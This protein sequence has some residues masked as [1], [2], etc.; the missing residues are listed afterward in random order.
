[1]SARCTAAMALIQLL[2]QLPLQLG[3]VAEAVPVGFYYN[4]AAKRHGA[5]EPCPVS[6]YCPGDGR[7]Y[8]CPPGRCC[9]SLRLSTL[10][11]DGD[12]LSGYFCR[13][14][15]KNCTANACGS[16]SVYCPRG[17][18]GPFT[19]DEGSFTVRSSAIDD[20]DR[21]W[22]RTASSNALPLS[23]FGAIRPRQPRRAPELTAAVFD[24]S[25]LRD[26]Q[27]PCDM[28]H[29]CTSGVRFTCP[30]GTFGST[31]ELKDASCSGPCSAG[32]WCGAGSV[33]GSANVCGG[34]GVFCPV[35]SAQPTPVAAGYYSL[36]A[37]DPAMRIALMHMKEDAV[38]QRSNSTR[39]RFGLRE[40]T[41]DRDNVHMRT[42]D[43]WDYVRVGAWTGL[44]SKLL[45]PPS[46]ITTRA[47]S[48]SSVQNACPPGTYCM[49]GVAALCPAGTFGATFGLVNSLCSGSCTS[50]FYCIAGST[51]AAPPHATCA[52]A[53]YYCPAASGQRTLVSDG[54]YT[55]GGRT[56]ANGGRTDHTMMMH[57]DQYPGS[58][59]F[60]QAPALGRDDP[61]PY[62]QSSFDRSTPVATVRWLN[63]AAGELD[64]EPTTKAVVRFHDPEPLYRRCAGGAEL[65]D[66]ETRSGQRP[67]P[68]G[69][70]CEKGWVI[71]CPPGTASNATRASNASAC[72]PCAPG[73]FCPG[74]GNTVPVPCGDA[75]V[76][77]PGFGNTQPISVIPGYV[78]IAHKRVQRCALGH[79]CNGG[80]ATPCPPGYWGGSTGLS[81]LFCSGQCAAGYFCGAGSVSPIATACSA[82]LAPADINAVYCPPGSSAPLNVSLGF[83]AT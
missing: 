12:C 19:A 72:Q 73:T 18:S 3:G 79:Y 29:Y 4:Y 32:H 40:S 62:T 48:T 24:D 51:L 67:C 7:A 2:L 26:S 23:Q 30:A 74:F 1:M 58:A 47:A 21:Q 50:G 10:F 60:S 71:H 82:G 55:M 59:G 77:C 61:Y 54:Y 9:S 34:P 41:A 42:G 13:A 65:G 53:S 52:N 64:D 38:E 37:F 36:P 49:E 14:G 44:E 69:A 20:R 70:Y 63:R 80:V 75:S 16:S 6:F 39:F 27:L 15:S 33:S 8:V 5:A 57:C 17:S 81:T 68:Q 78:S 22:H 76:Y 43:G 11:G 66:E 35:G 56:L 28:G 31:S 45:T 83:Y 46:L 25:T